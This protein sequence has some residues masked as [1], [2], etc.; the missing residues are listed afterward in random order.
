MCYE[1]MFPLCDNRLVLQRCRKEAEQADNFWREHVQSARANDSDS[2]VICSSVPTKA[3]SG[4]T[5]KTSVRGL[6]IQ[7]GFCFCEP[8]PRLGFR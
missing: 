8:Q 1:Y 3:V 2:T 5:S 6:I 7:T 4:F